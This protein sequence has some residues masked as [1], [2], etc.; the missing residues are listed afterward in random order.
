MHITM[1]L[2]SLV[3]MHSINEPPVL[4][5]FEVWTHSRGPALLSQYATTAVVRANN[6]FICFQE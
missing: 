2:C 4:P 3:V 6:K 1:V 5:L